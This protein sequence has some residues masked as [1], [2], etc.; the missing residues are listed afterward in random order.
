MT[1]MPTTLYAP[2]LDTTSGQVEDCATPFDDQPYLEMTWNGRE[3]EISNSP[4]LMGESPLTVASAMVNVAWAVESMALL[5]RNSHRLAS[6]NLEKL[7][8][9]P[10]SSDDIS[11]YIR[12]MNSSRLAKTYGLNPYSMPFFGSHT[13]WYLAST[14]DRN[15]FGTPY[16]VAENLTADETEVWTLCFTGTSSIDSPSVNWDDHEGIADLVDQMVMADEDYLE[17]MGALTNP[18][19]YAGDKDR[20]LNVMGVGAAREAYSKPRHRVKPR[21]TEKAAASAFRS[22][23]LDKA[24]PP[25]FSLSID[26]T[27]LRSGSRFR[28]DEPVNSSMTMRIGVTWRGS[29]DGYGQSDVVEIVD[30]YAPILRR[31]VEDQGLGL[32]VKVSLPDAAPYLMVARSVEMLLEHRSANG[33]P[34]AATVSEV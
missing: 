20:Y 1:K 18:D 11:G 15:A 23:M 25:A 10:D 19:G 27:D 14:E 7:G 13:R 3:V 34:L 2:L 30:E 24:R 28:F 29:Q 9:V 31:F 26:K 8:L 32:V 16:L 12:G 22:M 17:T 33:I 6:A 5:L 21:L 4:S